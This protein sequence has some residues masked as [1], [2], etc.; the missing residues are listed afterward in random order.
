MDLPTNRPTNQQSNM[1]VDRE[2]PLR[3]IY[4][5]RKRYLVRYS[6]HLKVIPVRWKFTVNLR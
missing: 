5:K 6:T 2:V 4:K 3:A 1:R